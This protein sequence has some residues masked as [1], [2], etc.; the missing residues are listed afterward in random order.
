MPGAA[1]NVYVK[2]TKSQS[3]WQ[4]ERESTTKSRESP[5]RNQEREVRSAGGKGKS[6]EH[7]KRRLFF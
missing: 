7:S 6:L 4:T 3:W 5:K 2:I 1:T